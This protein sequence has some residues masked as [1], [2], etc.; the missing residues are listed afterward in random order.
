MAEGGGLPS[1]SR[2]RAGGDPAAAQHVHDPQP[3]T[4][5][6]THE[7]NSSRKGEY[8]RKM[9]NQYEFYHRVGVG[10]H[11]EVYLARDTSKGNLFVVRSFRPSSAITLA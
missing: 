5:V 7:I 6:M 9:V 8:N 1:S 2:Y 10:Q 4:V 3:G 11:G